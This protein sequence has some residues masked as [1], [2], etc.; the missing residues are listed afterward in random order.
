M[1]SFPE[2]LEIA[3]G[4]TPDIIWDHW[5]QS[6]TGKV[7]C[8]YC[9]K[10][11]QLKHATKCKG[12]TAVCSYTP[13]GIK[14]QFATQVAYRN[15]Q[16][17]EALKEG[18]MAAQLERSS[19]Q[20]E[21]EVLST[22]TMDF[23]VGNDPSQRQTVAV[24]SEVGVVSTVQQMCRKRKQ[25]TLEGALIKISRTTH[26]ELEL[27]LAKAMISGNVPFQWV[28]NAHLK[29]FFEKL[30]GGFKTPSRKEIAG[31][32]LKKLDVWS[33]DLLREEVRNAKHISIVPDG[34]QNIRGASVVGVMLVNTT[35]SIFYRSFETGESLN[36]I[37]C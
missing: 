34:W 29:K 32:L 23:D 13:R 21:V 8:R 17:K 27:L 10:S 9:K 24:D 2:I 4:K 25:T 19:L 33:T 18:R 16:K 20:P 26:K 30:G 15:N 5:D 12:H 36:R 31:S 6:S 1:M 7:I 35:K 37:T 3:M 28:Q 22:T 14:L 11:E